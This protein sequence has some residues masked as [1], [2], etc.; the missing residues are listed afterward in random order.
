MQFAD[1]NALIAHEAE[2]MQL[3]IN[4]FSW[5]AKQFSLKINIKKTECLVQQVKNYHVAVQVKCQVYKAIVLS[6]LLHRAETWTG[7][8]TQ[9]KKLNSYMMR[10]LREIM[11]LTWKDK[12]SNNEIY[13]RTGLA[14]MADI[15]IERNLR[16]TGHVHRIDEERPLGSLS[17]H[18]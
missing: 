5:T 11:K 18:N 2:S 1:N 15:L 7:Y 6:T 4:R 9:V 13:R 16:W 14:P 17:T 3:L 12:V 8:R 10:H